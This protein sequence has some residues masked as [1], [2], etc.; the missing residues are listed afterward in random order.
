MHELRNAVESAKGTILSQ[1]DHIAHQDNAFRQLRQ[2]CATQE[3]DY[4]SQLEDLQ[5]QNAE[6]ASD[7][8]RQ[9]CPRTFLRTLLLGA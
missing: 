3:K 6:L 1:N 5:H 9:E 8:E 4:T 2:K 7:L